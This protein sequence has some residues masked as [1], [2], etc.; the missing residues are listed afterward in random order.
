M[1]H[2]VRW[3]QDQARAHMHTHTHTSRGIQA[4]KAK[5]KTQT[6]VVQGAPRLKGLCHSLSAPSSKCHP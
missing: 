2:P 1:S 3:V 5:A 6:R 4:E